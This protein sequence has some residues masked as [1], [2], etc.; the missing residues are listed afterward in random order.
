MLER[1]FLT[2][3]YRENIAGHHAER[4]GFLSGL[5]AKEVGLPKERVD[6]ISRAAPLHDVGK[7]GIPDT[8]LLKPGPL[9]AAEFEVMKTHTVIG[10]ELLSQG[11]IPLLRMARTIALSHHERWQGTGYPAG[12]EGDQI[13]L[14]GRITAVADAFD[15]LTHERAYQTAIPFREARGQILA[16]RNTSFD[17][18]VVDAFQRVMSV[19]SLPSQLGLVA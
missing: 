15:C 8:I 13:P 4:V 18:V 5:I 10:G 6:L 14:E 19:P 1:P 17:P 3:E 12:L 2:A 16:G 7:V 11:R 9:S